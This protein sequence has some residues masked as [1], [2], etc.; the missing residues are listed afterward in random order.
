MNKKYNLGFFLVIMFIASV[1]ISCDD[2]TE[3]EAVEMNQ[4]DITNDNPELYTKY[5]SNLRAYKKSEHKIVMCSYDNSEMNPSSRAHHPYD[6]PDSIDIVILKNPIDIKP[7]QHEEITKTRD[8]K[9]TKFILNIDFDDLKYKHQILSDELEASIAKGEVSDTVTMEPFTSY[10]IDSINY[11]IVATKE[12]NYDGIMFSFVGKKTHHMTLDEIT[13]YSTY[14]KIFISI[15]KDWKSRNQKKMLLFQ[16]KPQNLLENDFLA[17]CEYIVLATQSQTS[18]SKLDYFV[19]LIDG[20]NIPKDKFIVSANTP[21]LVE[22]DNETGYWVNGDYALTGSANWAMN[23]RTDFTVVGI[24]ILNIN[25]D[26]Y[27]RDVTYK[28]SKKVINILN[29]AIKN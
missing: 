27:Y 22:G 3:I 26:Y 16:G 1:A 5:L 24:S 25:N 13:E 10:L 9:G 23:I 20:E 28:L 29:P 14:H 15:L 12:F 17:D 8:D 2:W 7:W 18:S 6:L 11:N 21:S 19:N 4:A